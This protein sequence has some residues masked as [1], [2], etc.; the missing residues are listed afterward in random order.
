MG[1]ST[2]SGHR[3]PASLRQVRSHPF[4]G[5]QAEL[6]VLHDALATG[7]DREDRS[8]GRF[9]VVQGEGGIGKT[10]LV[11]A[12]LATAAGERLV[13]RGVA[14]VMDQR[15][16]F[17]V[18]LDA[19]GAFDGLDLESVSGDRDE[20]AVG[21]RLLEVVDNLATTPSLLVL[22]DLQWADPATLALLG[23]LSR[24]LAQLPLVVIGTLRPRARPDVPPDL[25][26]LLTLLDE[27]GLL[28]VNGLGPLPTEACVDLT[29]RLTGARVEGALLEHV[30]AAGGNPLFLTEIVRTLVDDG[31]LTVDPD[32]SARLDVPAGRSPSLAMVI[33]HHLSQLGPVTRELLTLAALLGTRFPASHLRVVADRPMSALVPPLREALA[34]GVLEDSGEGFLGFRHGLI[35]E[36]LLQDLT[37]AVRAELHREVAVRLEAVDAAPATVAGHLLQAHTQAEDLPWLSRLAQRTAASSPV[38]A[39][40]LWERVRDATVPG[41]PLHARSSAGRALS[42][43][44]TG[45][46]QDAEG[47]AREALRHEAPADALASLSTT[48]T[49]ALLLTGHHAS[50]RDEAER[51]AASQVLEPADRAVH[52]A[53]AGWP[54]FMVGDVSG[55]WTRA[56]EAAAMAVAV[57]S[58]DAQVLALVLQG[59]ILNCRGELDGAIDLLSD[60][61]A[62]ADRHPSLA[63]IEVFPHAQAAVAL[64][65]GDRV[66]EAAALLDRGRRISEQFGYVTGVFAVYTLGTLA[67][68]HSVSLSDLDSEL[69]ARDLLLD[70]IDVRLEPGPHALRVHV[71]A[72]QRGPDAALPWLR[73]LDPLPDRSTWP[74]RGR[75][76]IWRAISQPPR[77]RGDDTAALEV[78]WQGWEDCQAHGMLMDCAELGLD[79]VLL[80]QRVRRP[81][82]G[83]TERTRQVLEVLDGLAGRNP[84]VTH[85]RGTSLAVRGVLDGGADVLVEAATLLGGTPRRLEHARVS[86]LAALALARGRHPG[87]QAQAEAALHAYADAGADHDVLRARSALR[88]AGI[89][90]TGQPRARPTSGWE[91]LTRTEERIARQVATGASNPE[92]AQRFYL[93]RRTVESHVSHVLAKLG[94][95]SR[96]ELALYVSQRSEQLGE[97]REGSAQPSRDSR[98]ARRRESG[99]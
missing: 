23:R 62:V 33:M 79:L 45:R 51:A 44:R 82:E 74:G 27:R 20:Y 90:L 40:E 9:V 22:E 76:W 80:S 11:D 35:Q 55:A 18:L 84:T 89:R 97:H 57:G 48:L 60:A 37:T 19:F 53:F 71:A 88:R 50:A 6:S 1:G 4:V 83:S 66:G 59:H 17:A 28:T 70:E 81:G 29:E 24:T 14:D 7:G 94:L 63:A 2:T 96:I 86:E 25:D 92:I 47:I 61:V 26:H 73:R 5:R 68:S 32:G 16:P 38:T 52:L 87:A 36:V 99:P 78:L 3:L 72:H 49:H 13:L 43:L 98:P 41:D 58:R 56:T 93:S 85:L 21:E 42:A 54:R 64:G 46:A 95:R 77:A 34:A 15:R 10:S 69:D 8:L 12:A 30:A 67:L 31:A 65:D 39:V 91:A 75:S